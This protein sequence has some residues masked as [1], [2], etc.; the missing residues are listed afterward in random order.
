MTEIER[1]AEIIKQQEET[2]KQQSEINEQQSQE[3]Q[4]LKEQMA[5]LLKKLYSPSSER[6]LPVGSGQ[7][8]I[9]DEN[10]PFFKNQRQLRNKPLK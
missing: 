9:F 2:I 8:S 1:Q 4:L 3:I 7:L 5:Y 10:S 6:T